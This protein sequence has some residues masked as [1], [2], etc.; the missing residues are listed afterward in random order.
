MARVQAAALAAHPAAS[1]CGRIRSA[2][3]ST[4]DTTAPS[5]NPACTGAVSHAAPTALRCHWL[6]RAGTTAEA[7][8]HTAMAST[9]TSAMRPR[10]TSEYRT[11][12]PRLGRRQ[13]ALPPGIEAPAGHA[14]MAVGHR[15]HLFGHGGVQFEQM[16]AD[17]VGGPVEG[18]DAPGHAEQAP[19][20]LVTLR[21]IAG[22]GAGAPATDHAR[23]DLRV[24]KRVGD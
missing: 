4:A 18:G 22:H 24:T 14:P 3:P 9:S 13:L 7:A 2:R 8:N 6:A 20:K 11:S 21:L 17:L 15:R 1:R 5:T 10:R 19:R 23:Q 16:A 12:Q